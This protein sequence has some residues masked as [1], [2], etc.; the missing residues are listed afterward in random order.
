M[1]TELDEQLRQ[2]LAVFA[3]ES[4]RPGQAE[5]MRAVLSGRDCLC[6]MPTGGGKSLCYQLP[7]LLCDGVT[8]VVSPLIALMKDQV[9]ALHARGVRAT[10]I[11]STLETAEQHQRITQM[12]A[13]AYQLVYVAP[14]RLRSGA[15]M[16][17]L[18]Q[19]PVRLL[20][21]DEAHCISQWGHDFRPDYARLGEF[22]RHLRNPPTIALTA[23]ATPTVRD[24]VA[25]LLELKDPEVLVTGFARPNLYFES[26]GGSESWK[27]AELLQFLTMTRGAGIVYAATRRA[28]NDIA[29][30]LLA[31][32]DGKV[33]VYHAG[34]RLEDR[35]TVQESF[36][37][38]ETPVIVAT[39]AFGMGINKADLRFVV[40]Y[41][42]P[43]SLEAYYQEA[44]RAGRDGLPSRCLL[45]YSPK[46]R[47][48]QEFF[49]ENNYPSRNTVQRVYE[50]LCG[51][52]EN[53]IEL[54]QKELK[55]RLSLDVGG[56]GVGACEMLLERCGAI[57]R[58]ASQD[59]RASVRFDGDLA[60]VT[61]RLA[62]KAT[63]ARRVFQAL[64][65]IV[66]SR[67]G[68]RVYFP[69]QQLAEAAGL[70]HESVA[71]GLR[72]LQQMP[73]VDYRAPFRGRAIRIIDRDRP[74][75][76]LSIDFTMLERR[77]ANEYQKL[78]RMVEYAETR[79]CRQYTLLS[80]FGDPQARPCG[81]CDNCG[82]VAPGTVVPADRP[83]STTVAE[84]LLRCVRMA[85]SGVARTKGRA[86]MSLIAKMLCGSR[87]QA[88]QRMG[89]DR[90]STFGLFAHLRQT[91]VQDFLRVLLSGKLLAQVGGMSLRPVL[92]LTD[93]G[94]QVMHGK[95]SLETPLPIGPVLRRKL[96]A[97]PAPHVRQ[98]A[99]QSESERMVKNTT[100]DSADN[101][102]ELAAL[103]EMQRP[104]YYWTW[105]VRQVGFSEAE[106][107]T[108]RQLDPEVVA[109]HLRQ[110]RL[111]GL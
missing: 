19:T 101:R 83:D 14:E 88:V 7:A 86:S 58:L 82:G 53:P 2:Q 84:D 102:A 17:A 104:D 37:A 36:M 107:A 13:G 98:V 51:L 10:L 103:G 92:R 26:R 25:K 47:D 66:G 45:L 33:G 64:L 12:A 111:A 68:E 11:N 31:Q 42:I 27:D 59:N 67:E 75:E 44:G 108:I 34:M 6:I 94:K 80:Y 81:I 95:Q 5:V 60:R 46:D 100:E 96:L 28:C 15:F 106:C 55:E 90:L 76:S 69:P 9:D 54:T 61:S 71:R 18:Q 8:I 43:G 4:F 85:L 52:D 56:E 20:A 23:T 62:S 1:S 110:A 79:A 89:L 70:G 40:H 87:A 41:N 21:V 72:E 74:F 63:T 24:D 3:L 35:R 93:L 99:R 109:E 30:K 49:I 48:I 65:K 91:E 29:D 32:L 38:G 39:N 57:E 73:G 50:Y 78:D 16:E 22:R 97:T 77:K 105:R